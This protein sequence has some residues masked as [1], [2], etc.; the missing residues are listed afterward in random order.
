MY[1]LFI[2]KLKLL[3]ILVIFLLF[4]IYNLLI[5]DFEISYVVEQHEMILAE[6]KN[7]ITAT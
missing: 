5:N 1:K 2:T 7:L 4:I 3:R 6:P